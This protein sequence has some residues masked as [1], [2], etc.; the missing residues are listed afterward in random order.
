MV[1]QVPDR[2]DVFG[3]E[4]VPQHL[5][6]VDLEEIHESFLKQ[7]EEI[8]ENS[9]KY[10]NSEDLK[11]G[12]E[13][14]YTL[15]DENNNQAS[16]EERNRIKERDPDILDSELAASVIE[17]R[18]DPIVPDSLEKVES[19]VR[20]KEAFTAEV[21]A[22]E[23]FQLLRYGTNP[24]P[25]AEEFE[26]SGEEGDRYDV[27]TR[28]INNNRND[29]IVTDSFGVK[30]TFDPHEIHYS[31]M[32]AST[33][34]NLQAKSLQDAVDKANFA[35]MFM[36]YAEAM[37]AN[38]RI[39]EQKDTGISDLRIPLWAACSDLRS[40]EEFEAGKAPRA[41]RIDSYYG[42]QKGHDIEDYFERL[43]PIYVAPDVEGAPDAIHQAIMN[44]WKDVN[45]KFDREEG[46]AI[47]EMRPFSIQPSVTEDLAVSAFMIGRIAYAQDEQ[48]HGEGGEDLMD[49]DLVNENRENAMYN[50]LD[51]D[52]YDSSGELRDAMEVVR[53]ELEYARDGLDSLDVDYESFIDGE[54]DLFDVAFR[55]TFE[56]GMPPGDRS[57]EEY[58]K[59]RESMPDE[60]AL[61]EV[62]EDYKVKG[63][64]P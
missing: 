45:I 14:E 33:Q 52:L 57:A 15:L 26:R 61:A 21:A 7:V 27:F 35:Y 5:E 9:S 41:G 3:I 62:M 54:D 30:E 48:I 60:E 2:V 47:V 13:L 23:G 22:E 18:T 38:A 42:K 64:A 32:I 29:E 56:E 55:E 59:K 50:G 31:G 51:T 46:N 10:E 1:Q 28:F 53:D 4:D 11:V 37:G 12:F 44:N 19:E 36:P 17:A 25:T 16:G 8:L 49:I 6:G 39:M 43:D 63:E 20:G 58:N 34:T 40:N 24:F